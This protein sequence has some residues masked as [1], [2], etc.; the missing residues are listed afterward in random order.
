MLTSEQMDELIAEWRFRL[1]YKKTAVY[2]EFLKN[3]GEH[4]DWEE[5]LFF[6]DEHPDLEGFDWVHSL[7]NKLN[8]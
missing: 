4:A 1:A 3:Y 8:I 2:M 5:W 6:L 7:R